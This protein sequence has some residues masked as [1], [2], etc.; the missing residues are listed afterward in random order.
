MC[1]F[2]NFYSCVC[3]SLLCSGS[4]ARASYLIANGRNE[5]NKRCVERYLRLSIYCHLFNWIEWA[6]LRI[7]FCFN[8]RW[9]YF[10]TKSNE[11]SL[12]SVSLTDFFYSC[13]SPLLQRSVCVSCPTDFNH[14]S[15]AKHRAIPNTF[16]QTHY[17][18][19][20][21]FQ[22]LNGFTWR[23]GLRV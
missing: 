21:S 15:L 20:E 19:V 7:R 23:A 10:V 18:N 5:Y 6:C 3:F 16:P 14:F 13:F 8:I 1:C 4:C 9:I 2:F 22:R 17:I 11:F 12:V